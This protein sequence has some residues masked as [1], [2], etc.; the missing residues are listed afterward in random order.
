MTAFWF[1][2][3]FVNFVQA[4]YSRKKILK[5]CLTLKEI[6]F[7]TYSSKK[8]LLDTGIILSIFLVDLLLH[9]L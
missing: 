6:I 5:S 8:H 1:S 2:D 4:N 3:N 9:I 7:S